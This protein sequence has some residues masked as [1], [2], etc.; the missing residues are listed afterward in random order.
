MRRFLP[1][2]RLY[3]SRMNKGTFLFGILHKMY[4]FY[5]LKFI[6]FKKGEVSII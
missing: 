4:F 5:L 2:L 6:K 3:L 1:L